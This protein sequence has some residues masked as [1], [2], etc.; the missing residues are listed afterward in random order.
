MRKCDL[1]RRAKRNGC[2]ENGSALNSDNDRDDRVTCRT[3]VIGL[4]GFK[5]IVRDQA[6]AKI[7]KIIE[8]PKGKD[9][10]GMDW[11]EVNVETLREL[12]G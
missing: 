7:P 10:R 2:C 5:P 8:T 11:D 9:E 3:R 4:E 1:D 12:A 6:F